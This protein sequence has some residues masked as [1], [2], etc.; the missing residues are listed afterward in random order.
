M[1][2]RK[3]TDIATHLRSLSYSAV[4]TA[5]PTLLREAAEAI[6][7]LDRAHRDLWLQ[8]TTLRLDMEE[9]EDNAA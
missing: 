7:E 6:E 9:A 1:M 2:T 3:P 5:P 8:L 4:L